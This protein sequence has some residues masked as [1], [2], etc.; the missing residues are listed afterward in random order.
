M[1]VQKLYGADPESERGSIRR[2]LIEGFSRGSPDF[3]VTRLM[4]ELNRIA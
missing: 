4:D 1:H 2:G 3:D